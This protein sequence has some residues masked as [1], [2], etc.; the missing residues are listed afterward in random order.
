[1]ADFGDHSAVP[2]A[3]CGCSESATS[4]GM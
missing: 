1:M 4:G 3:G 2:A